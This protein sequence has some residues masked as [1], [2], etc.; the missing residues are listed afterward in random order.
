IRERQNA[1]AVRLYQIEV[2][3]VGW[4]SFRNGQQAVNNLVNQLQDEVGSRISLHLS[5]YLALPHKVN[6]LNVEQAQL[7]ILNPDDFSLLEQYFRQEIQIFDTISF[8]SFGNEQDNFIGS[9]GFAVTNK[10]NKN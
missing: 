9:S 6:Q 4:L 8:I 7:G 3:P 1:D 5:N 10:A 2:A